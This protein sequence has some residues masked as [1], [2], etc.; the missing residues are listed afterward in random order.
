M[1]L[2]FGN[3]LD[4]LAFGFLF[5]LFPN[6]FPCLEDLFLCKAL[7]DFS[8]PFQKC[9]LAVVG[10]LLL[11]SECGHLS[12]FRSYGIGVPLDGIVIEIGAVISFN[13]SYIL[14]DLDLGLLLLACQ[15]IPGLVGFLYCFLRCVKRS[16]VE[17]VIFRDLH[18]I[19][20]FHFKLL[21]VVCLLFLEMGP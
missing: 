16:C 18:Y 5:D 21:S 1:S 10:F 13:I 17:F 7:A 19:I 20:L 11:T 6:V 2:N 8:E 14:S 15:M 9:F 12:E 3:T 4:F